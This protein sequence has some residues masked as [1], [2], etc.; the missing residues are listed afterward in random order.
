ME[1]L[2]QLVCMYFVIGEGHVFV[3]VVLL[4]ESPLLFV[5]FRQCMSG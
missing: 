2:M 1:K 5:C 3:V 4:K